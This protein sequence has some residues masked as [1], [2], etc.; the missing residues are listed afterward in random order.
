MKTRRQCAVLLSTAALA[1]TACGGSGGGDEKGDV[2]EPHHTTLTVFAA[3]SL[4]DA[5]EELADGFE[6]EHPGV[7]VQ[8]NFAGSSA[9]VEQITA[10]APADVFA[11][12][13]E[14]IMD[15]AVE[16]GAV[17]GEPAPF[18]TN[19]LTIVTPR[20]NP[21]GVTSLRDAAADGGK[22]VVC[23]PQVP[24]GDAAL[25]VAEAAGTELSP[26]SEE[27][28]VT[29]VLGKVTS[30][31]ADAGLVY[32]TDAA[33]A[34]DSVQTVELEFAEAAVNQYPIGVLRAAE[35]NGSEQPTVAQDYMDYVLS[36]QGQSTLESHGFGS[37]Q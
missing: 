37:P 34:G 30:G 1:L 6:A 19:V 13:N 9:L 16:A 31:E 29:D 3:A 23:A 35:D 20:G 11:S 7:E 33:G 28:Q 14:A 36:G 4:A 27:S 25:T 10:G 12:A 21:A 5:F 8:Y 26:V 32:V 18:A 24:C 15:R 22:L 2:G 17:S